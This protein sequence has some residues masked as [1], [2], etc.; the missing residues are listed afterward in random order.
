MV[1]AILMT[2]LETT[3]PLHTKEKFHFGPMGAGL[4]FL[5]VVIPIFLAPIVGTYPHFIRSLSSQRSRVANT[6]LGWA[7]DKY[8]PRWIE[9]L[10]FVLCCPFMILLRLPNDD[11]TEQIVLMSALLVLLGIGFALM[12]PPVMAEI[13][14]ILQELEAGK[15]GIF[16]AN[17]A[18]A[19]G[20]R[21]HS[22]PGIRCGELLKTDPHF[23][24]FLSTDCSM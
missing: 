11:S 9:T 2:G 14:L 17:G 18:Y 4:I 7:C 23:L 16:G 19:Q 5:G 1:E 24:F 20:V 22:N 12:V 21:I 6:N 15:P 13:T 8:G 10:G 3:L